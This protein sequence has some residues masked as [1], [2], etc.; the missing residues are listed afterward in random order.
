[1]VLSDQQIFELK[2]YSLCIIGGTTAGWLAS[3]TL[4]EASTA[5]VFGASLGSAIWHFTKCS[6]Q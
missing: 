4:W 1:M 3:L 5:A 6:A 2:L